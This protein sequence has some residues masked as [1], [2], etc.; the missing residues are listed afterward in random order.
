M[1][2]TGHGPNKHDESIFPYKWG[3]KSI[4]YLGIQLSYPTGSLYDANFTPLLSNISIDLKRMSKTQLSWVGRAAAFKMQV[5]PKI[6]YLFRTLPIPIPIP[7]FTK[8]NSLLLP[9]MKLYLAK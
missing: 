1:S 4:T 8:C 5:L 2:N 7:F 6:L 3:A 9:I